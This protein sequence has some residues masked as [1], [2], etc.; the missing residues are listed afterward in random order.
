MRT[1]LHTSGLGHPMGISRGWY[2]YMCEEKRKEGGSE[3]GMCAKG[4]GTEVEVRSSVVCVK[5]GELW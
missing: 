2:V 1:R 5:K 4:L 3:G